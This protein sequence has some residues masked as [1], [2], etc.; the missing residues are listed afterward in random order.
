MPAEIRYEPDDIWVLQLSGLLKQSEFVAMQKSIAAKISIGHKPRILAILENF[1]GWERGTDW[2]DL[3]FLLS[4]SAEIARI[5]IVG[6]RHWE[7]P[8]LAFAGAGVRRAPVKFFEPG[9][10]AQARAWLRE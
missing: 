8:G 6:E 7:V 4:H 1:D 3:D 2:N 5:A 9:E 10:L